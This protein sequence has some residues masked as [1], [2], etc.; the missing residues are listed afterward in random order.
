MR[1]LL[2]TF[3]LLLAV[4]CPLRAEDERTIADLRQVHALLQAEYELVKSGKL[5]LLFDLQE[6][7]IQLKGSGLV[8]ESWPIEHVRTW[9]HPTVTA[10]AAL[11]RKTSFD[12]P[13]RDVQVVRPAVAETGITL[14]KAFEV[15]DMPTRYRLHLEN[16]TVISVR[17]LA[18]PWLARLQNL[19]TLPVWYLSRP[20]ISG[21]NS[22]RGSPYNEIA[23]SMTAQDA[24]MLYWA[25]SENTLCLIRLPAAVAAKGPFPAGA[26]RE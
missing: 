24:R 14:P 4:G 13:E 20:L 15:G 18:E 3:L 2:L 26:P 11:V 1:L 19:G 10:A 25:F 21:W 6:K 9:G 5:F 12:D 8:L 17:P 23:L 7:Q 22:L 16:G